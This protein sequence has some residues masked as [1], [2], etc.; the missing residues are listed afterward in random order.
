MALHNEGTPERRSSVRLKAEIRVY[1]GDY[2]S[3][4]LTGYSVNLTSGGIFLATTCPFDVDDNVK[5]KFSMPGQEEQAVS[6]NA[7]VAWINYEDNWLKPEY[8]TGV[9]LQFVDLSPEDLCSIVGFLEV[10]AAW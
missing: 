7:R 9:G 3:K 1:Y 10:K 6:C 5:L 8:P 4:L 2:H